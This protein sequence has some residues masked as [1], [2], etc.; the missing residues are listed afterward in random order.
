MNRVAAA[1]AELRSLAPPAPHPAAGRIVL[2]LLVATAALAAF[3]WLL[4]SLWPEDRTQAR[5]SR[6]SRTNLAYWFFDMLVDRRIAG[7]G[8]VLVL[9]VLVLLRVPRAFTVIGRQP[10]ALQA[11]E[12][13]L[14]GDFIGYWVHRAMHEVPV[15]W[16]IHAIHHSSTRLD[17]LAS[18]R[19]HPLES[20]IA[21][22]AVI[23]PVFLLGF[24]P[25]ITAFY[26][27]FLG[28]YPIFIHC[29]LRW[30]YGK[31]GYVIASPSFHR[32]HHASDVEACDKNFSGL[33]PFF[34]YLFGTA[35]FPRDRHPVAYG[36]RDERMP[37]GILRQ[38]AYPFRGSRSRQPAVP[39]SIT[40]S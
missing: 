8:V 9:L 19:L 40:L 12:V 33:F 10:L 17:W 39:G 25:G 35:Y 6:A 30:G 27:P 32:W 37:Y 34:D 1:I 3:F 15:L 13:L 20:V 28:I 38:L 22:L 18:A 36:L 11:L 16:R 4:E 14:L 23:V 5:W 7:I 31:A 29:N 24:S 21:R 26:G 2:G